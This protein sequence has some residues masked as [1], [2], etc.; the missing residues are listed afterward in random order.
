MRSKRQL[1]PTGAY[2]HPVGEKAAN[3]CGLHDTLA[4][5]SE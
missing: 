4:N 1:T 5:V 3:G 2:T